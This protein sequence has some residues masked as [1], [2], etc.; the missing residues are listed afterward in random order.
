LEALERRGQLNNTI[1]IFTSDNGG[2]IPGKKKQT[3]GTTQEIEPERQALEAGLALNGKWRGDKHTIYEGGFRVPLIVSYP[4]QLAGGV[5]SDAYVTTADFFATIAEMEGTKDLPETSA[6]DSFSFAH[7]LRDP[8]APSKRPHT[9]LNDVQ[10]RQ[11]L[12]FGKW[13]MIDAK[14]PNKA[15]LDIELYDIEADP[16]ETRDV[17]QKHPEVIE[18]GQKL[19]Q[20]IRDAD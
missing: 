9:V 10:G 5:R 18:Q 6:P 20:A 17:A 13:K 14:V 11:A 8:T 15:D 12:R 7:V 4:A 2:D 3:P 19:L 16:G 1:F